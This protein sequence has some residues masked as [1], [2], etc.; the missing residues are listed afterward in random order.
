M[1]NPEV[2][3]SG[4]VHQDTARVVGDYENSGKYMLTDKMGKSLTWLDVED[5]MIVKIKAKTVNYPGWQYLQPV[6]KGNCF[7][8]FRY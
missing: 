3:L 8:R 7:S 6:K 5:G 1:A 4:G 2:Q